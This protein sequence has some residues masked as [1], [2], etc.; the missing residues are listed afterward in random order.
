MQLCELLLA[1]LTT[2]LLHDKKK[3]LV[4]REQFAFVCIRLLS[5]RHKPI[6][7]VVRGAGLFFKIRKLISV[8]KLVAKEQVTCFR[9]TAPISSGI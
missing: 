4:H 2:R 5:S 9:L 6:L 7:R 3:L 8:L 1:D